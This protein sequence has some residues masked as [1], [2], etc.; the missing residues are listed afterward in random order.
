MILL[1][2]RW[3]EKAYRHARNDVE[4]PVNIEC[5]DVL[6]AEHWRKLM[7]NLS[8]EYLAFVFGHINGVVPRNSQLAANHRSQVRIVRREL[9]QPHPTLQIEKVSDCRIATRQS[10]PK[11][12]GIR[13][14]A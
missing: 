8:S 6:H 3:R 14:S 11:F 10:R 7:G 4:R 5:N 1:L 12:L 13:F 2:R 9:A